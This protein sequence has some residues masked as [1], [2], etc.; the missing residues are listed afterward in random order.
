MKTFYSPVLLLREYFRYN[1][2]NTA[3]NPPIRLASNGRCGQHYKLTL[4]TLA[5]TIVPFEGTV[6]VGCPKELLSVVGF[7]C[8]DFESIKGDECPTRTLRDTQRVGLARLRTG[9]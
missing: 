5:S 7:P 6:S 8:E 2:N 1:C 9:R 4:N 3:W